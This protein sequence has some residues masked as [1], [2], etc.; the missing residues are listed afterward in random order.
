MNRPVLVLNANYAPLQVCTTRRALG[1]LLKEKAAILI[2]GRGIIHTSSIDLLRPSVIRL[3]YMVYPPRPQVRLSK[4]EIF[5][6]DNYTC[7]YC[8]RK[9][10]NLTVDHMI[11][12][13]RG[14]QHSWTNLVTACESCNHR[15]GGRTPQEA[16]MTL[17]N[18]PTE[19]PA[20]ARYLYQRFLN[21]NHDW[22]PY[23]EGW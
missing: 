20:T 1:L 21:K 16:R 6:R 9:G 4:Q 12:R 15:K 14:G 18:E 19:P 17:L 3:S 2:N 10:G 22:F 23:V 13:H 11:P 8:G 7:Q 5:R